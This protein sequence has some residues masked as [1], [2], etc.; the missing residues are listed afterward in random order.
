[1]RRGLFFAASALLACLLLCTAAFAQSAEEELGS[2][3]DPAA[4]LTEEALAQLGGFDCSEER[5]W[6]EDLAGL[7]VHAVSG[8]SDSFRT[9]LACASAVLAAAVLCSLVSG[10]AHGAALSR[11][12]GTLAITG[13]VAGSVNASLTLAV[14]TVRRL[15]E[16][17]LLLL[18]SL[19]AL[20]TA[21]GQPSAGAAVYAAGAVFLDVLLQLSSRLVVPLALLYAACCAAD[22][23]IGGG[24]LAAL[25]DFLKWLASTLLKWTTYV[26]TG[27][28]TVSGVIGGSADA[29]RQKAARVAFSGA[30]PVVGSILADSADSILAAASAVRSAAGIY[31]MLAVLALCLGPFLRIAL[32]YL[33]LKGSAALCGL[34]G[35]PEL[36]TLADKLS[37]ALGLLLALVGAYAAAMFL[38]VALSMKAVGL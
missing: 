19:G 32:Q 10:L 29:V 36:T 12:L 16:Y 20:S 24:R 7:L 4:G 26:F 21:A 31:G 33:L 30:V 15:N 28:L 9:G 5:S 17:G 34:F 37:D 11:L 2:E 38:C 22:C 13:A 14:E 3:I 25:R 27:Y 6:Q 35:Q 23:A 18:P 1:M 8:L